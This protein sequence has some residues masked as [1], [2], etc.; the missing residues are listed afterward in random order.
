M[1]VKK[2]KNAQKSSSKA[3]RITRL[4]AYIRAPES[5]RLQEKCIYAGARNF[6]TDTPAGQA[7][8]MIALA[9]ESVRSKDPIGALCAQLAGR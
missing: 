8:E 7:A 4:T 2:V 9:Q 6:I 1:I 3:V 5:E